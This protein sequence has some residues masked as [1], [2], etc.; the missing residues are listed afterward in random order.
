MSK[1]YVTIMI[2]DNAS[3]SF[4]LL[5]IIINESARPRALLRYIDFNSLPIFD[6]NL[7]S[8]LI[9]VQLFETW[10]FPIICTTCQEIFE[11]E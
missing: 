7:K 10:F 6:K 11:R 3:G 9:D 5:L 1:E 2:C 8:A 4:C